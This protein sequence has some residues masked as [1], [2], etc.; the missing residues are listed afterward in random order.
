MQPNKENASI[1]TGNFNKGS[2]NTYNK[3][4]NKGNNTTR[5]ST[6]T[7]NLLIALL[8]YPKNG[9]YALDVNQP[10]NNTGFFSSCLHSDISYIRH[11]HGIP[12]TDIPH[13]VKFAKGHTADFKRYLLPDQKAVKKVCALVNLMREKRRAKPLSDSQINA[14]LAKFPKG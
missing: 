1:K 7:E 11:S 10:D 12:V 8:N 5:N 6:K 2:M 3:T 4:N 14:Y 13:K 9:L